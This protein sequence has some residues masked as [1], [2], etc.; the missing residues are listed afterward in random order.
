[1]TVPSLSILSVGYTN[2]SGGCPPSAPVRQRGRLPSPWIRE[3][4]GCPAR[5]VSVGT[6]RDVAAARLIPADPTRQEAR[7]PLKR[8]KCRFGLTSQCNAHQA[9][10]PSG[11]RKNPLALNPVRLTAGLP[12]AGA[13][14]R[15]RRRVATPSASRC[16]CHRATVYLPK[17]APASSRPEGQPS[18]F[19]NLSWRLR[20]RVADANR[21]SPT[22]IPDTTDRPHG[23]QPGDVATTDPAEG[24]EGFW[25]CAG[26][27]HVPDVRFPSCLEPLTPRLATAAFPGKA[28]AG[29]G[30]SPPP[31]YGLPA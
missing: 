1:M 18:L 13:N 4:E 9:E 10:S 16:R 11:S 31:V 14:A 12:V 8:S 15:R 23:Y 24:R 7:V 26:I 20:R 25:R 30:C 29:C 27:R 17:R 6:P 28:W 5:Q 21:R 22:A 19:A 2:T 3:V